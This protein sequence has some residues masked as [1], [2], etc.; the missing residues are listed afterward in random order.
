MEFGKGRVQYEDHFW[1]MMRF[2]RFETYFYQGGKN[3]AIYTAQYAEQVLPEIEQS[4]ESAISKSLQ[5][6]IYNNLS[7]L[8]QSNIGLLTDQ[9]YNTGGVTYIVGNKI[10]LYFNG[11]YTHFRQQIRAG[12]AQ[13]A[14]NHHHHTSWLISSLVLYP[15]SL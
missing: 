12:I 4:S 13:V 8:K 10:F 14:L 3:L 15:F 1:S 5:F 6:I 2:D 7:D 11:D 9:S